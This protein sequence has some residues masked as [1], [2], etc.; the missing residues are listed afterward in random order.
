MRAKTAGSCTLAYN[1]PLSEKL[2]AFSGP[3]YETPAEVR[4]ARI[5]GGDAVVHDRFTRLPNLILGGL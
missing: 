5:M 2:F 1:C 4:C 3:N